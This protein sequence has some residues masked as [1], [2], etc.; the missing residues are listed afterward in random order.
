MTTPN[1]GNE[2]TDLAERIRDAIR[3]L[4]DNYTG[5]IPYPD[6]I[7]LFTDCLAALESKSLSDGE[8]DDKFIELLDEYARDYEQYC[9]AH[10]YYSPT[11]ILGDNLW[12][13]RKELLQYVTALHDALANARPE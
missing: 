7:E 9:Y 8:L 4:Q 6:F 10:A 3:Q 2:K 13:S 5:A 1:T 11:K 12:E